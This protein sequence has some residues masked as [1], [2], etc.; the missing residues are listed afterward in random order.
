MSTGLG[1]FR[2]F[3]L[4]KPQLTIGQT[5][6]N[7]EEP[8]FQSPP[9]GSH[10]STYQTRFQSLQLRQELLKK[11]ADAGELFNCQYRS[12]ATDGAAGSH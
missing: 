7:A 10:T 9:L 4:K 12:G 8:K 2:F 11:G 3:R 5:S 1:K 6:A